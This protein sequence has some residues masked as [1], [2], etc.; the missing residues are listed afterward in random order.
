MKLPAFILF[1][2]LTAITAFCD[3]SVTLTP[4]SGRLLP[5]GGSKTFTVDISGYPANTT[6]LGLSVDLPRSN[7]M[8][9]SLFAS[10]DCTVIAR[11][12]GLSEF[13]TYNDL[14]G[15]LCSID[16]NGNVTERMTDPFAIGRT[17]FSLFD[18][19]V[20]SNGNIYADAGGLAI[21]KIDSNNVI[22]LFAGSLTDSGT[23]DGQGASARFTMLTG[24]MAFDTN[25]N[26]YVNDNGG[27]RKITQAGNVSTITTQAGENPMGLAVDSSGNIF[28]GDN[29]MYSR[30]GV[31]IRKITPA[32]V[33]SVFTGSATERGSVDGNSSIARF[34]LIHSLTCDSN[35][36][37]YIGEYGGF[38]SIGPRIRKVD[39]SANTVTV[40]G[41]ETA[42]G[43]AIV[44]GNGDR[45]SFSQPD[46]IAIDAS[47]NVYVA[48]DN[49]IVK[50]EAGPQWT[51]ASGTNEPAIRPVNGQ[52]G[53]LEWGYVS[54]PA[55]ATSFTFT[56]SYPAGLFG[57]SEVNAN[58][59]VRYGG[60]H[61]T[62]VATPV[63]L[64]N[65][66][67]P[68]ISTSDLSGILNVDFSGSIT[69]TSDLPITYSADYLPAGLSIDST[70]GTIN[71]RVMEYHGA[72][73]Y[74]VYAS[75]AVGRTPERITVN[76]LQGTA[77]ITLSDMT[78]GWSGSPK[79]PTISAAPSNLNWP[80]YTSTTYNGS[81]TAP[82]EPGTYSVVVTSVDRWDPE[83]GE[84]DYVG[85]A[86][87]TL[88]ITK[89][90][91]SVALM[92]LSQTYNGAPK[93]VTASTTPGG[94]VVDVTYNGSTT[95]PTNAGSYTAIATI[96]N[97]HYSGTVTETFTI[98]KAS[99]AVS[100]SSTSYTYD[101]SAK[102][103][104]TSTI[105]AGLTVA[106][107]YDGSGTTPSAVGS[108]AVSANIVDTNYTG[109]STGTLTINKA[110]SSISWPAPSAIT[111]GTRLSALQ[112]NAS[113]SV[114]GTLTYTPVLNTLL[115]AGSGQ[116]L[117]VTL[118]PNDSN[119]NS[120]SATV[121]ID[122]NK[123]PLSVTASNASRAYGSTNPN[124]SYNITGFV[125]GENISV[126]SGATSVTT[127]AT[128]A[129]TVGTY[130][131]VVSAGTLSASNYSLSFVNGSLTVTKAH[132]SVA[133][134]NLTR[135]YGTANPTLTA[136]VTGFVNGENSSAIYGS[137]QLTTTATPTS[138]LGN[139][140][141]TAAI[142]SLAAVN[143]DFVFSDG[144]LTVSLS[145]HAA[146]PDSN[147]HISLLEL[148]RVIEIYN[149]MNGASRTGVYHT[150]AGTEDGYA[151]GAGTITT[152]H[153][154]DTNFDGKID[155][156]ELSR[157]IDLYNTKAG[158]YRTGEYHI[159]LNTEDMYAPG[160]TL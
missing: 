29:V 79:S 127:A 96:F 34:Y 133:A 110:N 148:T 88:T 32:G 157:V 47:N 86:T 7:A 84:P 139:Y 23:T 104:A 158:V 51:Y 131:I 101:G 11:G 83:N 74:T 156:L 36:N 60:E 145:H 16:A 142:G 117:N 135:N 8:T 3:T 66:T 138:L 109:S 45:A 19:A 89:A 1:L 2:V 82:T 5:G 153:S 100:I 48:D 10:N 17:S 53:T 112:L 113:G 78:Q 49:V 159:D 67:R 93:S 155:L 64:Q 99:A 147:W 129:S 57:S 122:V 150:Q 6:V 55:S 73:Y 15:K 62:I 33:V 71:G 61:S 18:I 128:T 126:L 44:Y 151:T 59:I 108:Y 115:A 90:P 42:P 120:V 75:N 40:A 124:L 4:N 141:I 134:D 143:Y 95:L 28:V 116:S 137:P 21:V 160:P 106:L 24:G 12:R 52:T 31:V 81:S 118:T 20:D 121:N 136:T 111:Y 97:A 125:D 152:Y 76:L 30:G 22:T 35:D 149:T 87:G 50:L 37:L 26:L 54:I 123:A 63:V 94:L 43:N 38:A 46:G 80:I 68:T 9:S 119:Y 102:S 65:Y 105:P 72:S 103:V 154:A 114:P 70:T 25:D 58:L 13:I 41:W 85:S 144:V 132:L 56:V 77:T 27:I 91:A 92:N 69:A 107:T 140:L 146:D 14:T 39:S 130:P 98:S